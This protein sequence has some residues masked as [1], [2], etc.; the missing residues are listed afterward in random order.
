MCL[1]DE[2]TAWDT[3]RILCT[4]T[5]HRDPHNPLRSPGSG[6]PEGSHGRLAAVCGVEYAAQAMAVHG[7][8]LGASQ[9][10][11][12]AGFLTS[13]RD[14]EAQVARLDTIDGTLLVEAE[15]MSGND[16]HILYRF[17]L[18]CG[19]RLLLSGRATVMLDASGVTPGVAL[20]NGGPNLG[21]A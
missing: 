14:V 12:R 18:R 9:Q 4:A 2:V 21:P 15:R 20:S 8:L 16:N 7:A 3:E 13:V 19:D 5:S 17:A 10:R 1:L 6:R 11:P